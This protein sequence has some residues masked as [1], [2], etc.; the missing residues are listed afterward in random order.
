M[1]RYNR[2]TSLASD[3]IKNTVLL[4]SAMLRSGYK[5]NLLIQQVILFNNSGAVWEKGKGEWWRV[6]NEIVRQMHITHTQHTQQ[7]PRV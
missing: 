5:F 7:H 3:F 4:A 1:H 6:Q 2:N